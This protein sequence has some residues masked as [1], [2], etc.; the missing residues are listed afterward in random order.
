MNNITFIYGLY[1]KNDEKKEIRYIGKSDNP[2]HRLKRHK[3]NTKY[4]KKINKK[5]T[6]KENWIISCDYNIDFIILKECDKNDWPELERRLIK[7]YTRLTNTSNGGEGGSGLKYHI[8]YEDCKKWIR[9]NV[10][11]KSKTEWYKNL[12]KLSD[13]IP[14]NPRQR[15][16]NDGWVSW[17]DFLGTGR[18]SDNYVNYLNYDDAKKIIKQLNIKKVVIYRKLAKNGELQ[19][20]IPNRP[21]R[22]YK[23]R[24]WV[25]WGDFLSCNIIANQNKKFFNLEEFKLNVKKLNIKKISE[26]KKYCLSGYRDERMPTNPLI[27]YRRE[28]K[29]LSWQDIINP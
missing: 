28:Y 12:D 9:E 10:D 3:D 21:E 22:Y 2:E 4:R 16:K 8:S 24:G 20:D 7:N 19:N 13:N 5:L 29:G 1:H 18:V 25:S 23:S 17:G 11:I 15:Y 14:K 26:Y 27:V 6:H